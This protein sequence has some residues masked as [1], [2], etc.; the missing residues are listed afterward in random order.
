[1]GAT[2][3]APYLATFRGHG[4]LL[5]GKQGVVGAGHARDIRLRLGLRLPNFCS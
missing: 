1:M 3:A 5:Q 4:P 2:H